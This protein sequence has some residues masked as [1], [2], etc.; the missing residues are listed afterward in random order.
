MPKT[1]IKEFDNTGKL[2]SGGEVVVFIPGAGTIVKGADAN[3]CVY[4]PAGSKISDFLSGE[5]KSVEYASSLNA[6]G[7]NILYCANTTI[8]ANSL[9]FLLDKNAYK[10]RFLTSGVLGSYSITKSATRAKTK[11]G[12]S[13][14]TETQAEL[15]VNSVVAKELNRIAVARMDC[16]SLIDSTKSTSV[17]PSDIL[18]ALGKLELQD[19]S[20]AATFVDWSGD[21]PGSFYYLKLVAKLLQGNRRWDSVAGVKRG[22]GSGYNGPATLKN[23]LSKYDLDTK[24]QMREGVS[25][26]GF[27]KVN[28]VY[29]LWGDRT[30]KQNSGLTAT[31][32]L[33]IRLL[34]C[35][36]CERA[37]VAAIN[38][39]FESNNDVTW[40]NY[41]TSISG[42]LDQAVADYKIAAYNIVKLTPDATATI[43]CKIRI[44]PIEPVEDFVIEIQIENSD[45]NIKG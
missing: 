28:N 37:Y 30:L 43:R 3:K 38:N 8:T 32:F 25:F 26:N 9:D 7:L 18:A 6:L 16:V 2:S 14:G 29:T 19:G 21:L 36:I 45:V 22:V 33:S 39:T 13:G 34:I 10:V 40:A 11:D 23:E 31:S 15:T 42:L 5:D 35:D 41:K 24:Y 12:E 1:I 44:V 17:D 20:Y 4:I 27:V